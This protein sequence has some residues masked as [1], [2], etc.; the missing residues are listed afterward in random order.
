MN[1]VSPA[2]LRGL[3]DSLPDQIA[4]IRGRRADVDGLIGLA[5]V[6]RTRVRVTVHSNGTDAQLAACAHDTDRNLSAICD[7]HFPQRSLR[8][9]SC[10]GHGA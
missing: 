9:F 6:D 5:C 10:S 4:F 7:E 8:G 3:D 1:R 2:S